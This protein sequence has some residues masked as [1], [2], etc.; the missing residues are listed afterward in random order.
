MKQTV[1]SSPTSAAQSMPDQHINSTRKGPEWV[2]RCTLAIRSMSTVV[3]DMGR[4]SRENK[5]VNYDLVNSIFREE[6]FDYVLNPYGFDMAKFGGTPTKMQN[7]N[8]IR[9]RLETLRGEE[10][11]TPLSFFVYA[12]SG[13]AVSA[14][15]QKRKD[16]LRDMMKAH[17]RV[18]YQLDETINKLEDQITELHSAMSTMKDQSQL[19]NLQQQ[20]NELQKQRQGMPD[21][22]KEMERF[23]SKY[24]DPTEQTNNKILKF[25]KRKDKLALKFNQ[26]WFHALVSAEEIYYTGISRGHP[27]VRACNPLQIDYDK[28]ANTTFIHEGNWVKEEMWLPI[29]EVISEYGDVLTTT[30]VKKIADGHAGHNYMLNGMQQGFVYS[31]SGG[32]RRTSRARGV[33]SHVYIMKVSWRSF[34]KVGMLRY[35]DPR[36]GNWEEVEVD[37]TFKMTPELEALGAQIEWMWDD[38]IWESTLIGDNIFVNGRP[39]NNQ[40]KNLPYIGY[41]YNN[42]NSIAT[43]LV[44][45]VKAHQ[46]TYIVVWWR[47]EQELAK[48]KGK[49]FIM[50]MA[51]L[52]KSMG[53][54]VDKWMYYFE[55]VGVVWINSKE[56][57]RKGDPS[58]VAQFNQ[59]NAIDMS[60][61]Q[62]VVQYMAVLE[63]L[64]KLVE[65]IMG[66]SPQRMGDVK[67]SETATGAQTSIS[68]STNVTRPWFYFHDLVKEAVLDELLELAKIAYIDGREMEL[69]LDEFEVQ[70][71]VIDGDKLNGSQMG[72][73]V[74]NSYEDRQNKD[75]MENLLTIAVQQGKASLVDVAK[76]LDSKSMSYTISTLEAG[77]KQAAEAADADSKRR[78]ETAQKAQEDV[79][80]ERQLDRSLEKE[81]SDDN[82]AK[83]ILIKK[84]DKGMEVSV[85]NGDVEIAKTFADITD[86]EERLALDTKKESNR[87]AEKNRELNI[88]E[89]EVAIKKTVANK[90]KT[91]SS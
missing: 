21:I 40:T 38:E 20:L 5:E 13:E 91:Q 74:T 80:L 24:V 81:L 33:A 1:T 28:G 85:D 34:A 22:Q 3:D 39:K 36:T 26:G 31:Y 50:D 64:E 56:E 49:K 7:Y 44:D 6:D 32:Q 27:S 82:I 62:V 58:S 43:S 11:N 75:K 87:S 77:E 16:V 78:A 89:K 76:T 41:I 2:R 67:P 61:S 14:K 59:F 72:V 25:L 37:D 57:G 23:N 53:W 17:I 84:I 86:S 88:K 8:I 66:V 83:D 4:T 19:Q 70:T 60:L 12:I 79:K 69:V 10:M 15:K 9:S 71:L 45:L 90:P 30:Q 29:G 54:D 47:L 35:K 51:Q 42:V 46:Y 55:N 18:E 68:R 73:F 52:P 65:D 63:K 48:A